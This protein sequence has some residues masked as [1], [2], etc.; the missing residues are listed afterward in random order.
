MAQA[1]FAYYTLKDFDLAHDLVS[2]AIGLRPSDTRLYMLKTWIERRQGD[3]GARI[4]TIREA[5]A[6]DP[7]DPKW[8]E[9]LVNNLVLTHRYD[10]A[11]EVVANTTFSGYN[12]ESM[13]ALLALREHGDINRWVADVERLHKV[14][15]QAARPAALHE[16]YLAQRDY[17][18]AEGVLPLLRDNWSEGKFDDPHLSE[19]YLA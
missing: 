2:Q 18:A 7:R 11:E 15:E 10:E 14:Y 5:R 6:L 19:R 8:T 16:A 3:F 4:E 12:L 1:F 17:G 9:M 13:G